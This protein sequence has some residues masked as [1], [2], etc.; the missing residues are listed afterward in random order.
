MKATAI[1]NAGLLGRFLHIPI[2]PFLY[3]V[4]RDIKPPK[5]YDCGDFD[6]H[7]DAAISWL[8]HAHDM[9]PDDGVCHSYSLK[10][11]WRPSYVET[12]G[13]IIETFYEL[14]A[15]EDVSAYA[16]RAERMA[17]WLLGRQLADG[18]FPNV[19]LDS[20]SGLVFDTGQDLFGLI[21]AYTE[22]RDAQFLEAALKAGNW[23][24]EISDNDDRWTQSTYKNIPHVYNSRTA[25]ALLELHAVEAN[26]A[27]ERVARA[28]LDWAVS[29]QNP[30]GWFE[31]CAFE[32][33]IAPFTHTIAYATR[34][35]LE[36]SR[37]LSEDR[38]LDSAVLAADA[39][40]SQL[41]DDGFLP[42]QIATDGTPDTNYCCLTGNCQFA[43]VWAKL[44]QNTGNASYRDAATQAWT[45]VKRRQQM[46]SDDDNIH[47]GIAGSFPIWGRYHRLQYPNWAAKFFIDA[48]LLIKEIS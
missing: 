2:R 7:L 10:G 35:L 31:Q 43:I 4:Y 32:Q 22:T 17:R 44:F 38:Y 48:A 27:F 8:E 30:L 28:N 33:R 40:I 36:S 37:L 29:E 20:G 1:S 12:T 15:R 14:A 39:A 23:L 34:G 26:E 24:T 21:R 42:G 3:S 41:H 16:D 47:G 9:S 5:R 6:D 11:G 45:Y 46:N 13:Y 25:W 19:E 18:S